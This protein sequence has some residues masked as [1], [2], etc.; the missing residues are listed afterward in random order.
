MVIPSRP[1]PGSALIPLFFNNR[2]YRDLAYRDAIALATEDTHIMAGYLEGT[3]PGDREA[4][5]REDLL[6]RGQKVRA[7]FI[8]SFWHTMAAVLTAVV[9]ALAWG[10][11]GPSLDWN[12]SKVLQSLGGFLAAWGT[13]FQLGG[14]ER[15]WAGDTLAE[16]L[17]GLLFRLVFLPGFLLATAGTLW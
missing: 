12:V 14:S 10:R 4:Q 5:Y 7:S 8:T 1:S 9:I 17:P 3:W 2:R 11:F 16:Q 15:T 13:I 6:K